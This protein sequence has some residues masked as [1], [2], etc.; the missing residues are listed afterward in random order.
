M[1]HQLAVLEM[2]EGSL[3]DP[4]EQGFGI[5]RLQDLGQRVAC[6]QLADAGRGGQQVQVVVA[7]H[8]HAPLAQ[9][10]HLAQRGQR[11]R[12]AVDEVAGEPERGVVGGRQAGQQ[13]D[14]GGVATLEVADGD[15]HRA[16]G[17]GHC[18]MDVVRFNDV[19][20]A[21]DARYHKSFRA[22]VPAACEGNILRIGIFLE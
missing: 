17:R 6:L 3:A 15:R 22:S 19:S 1:H 13:L 12:P 10:D 7:E 8:G 2:R 20:Q 11:G 9:R 5:G 4:F 14:E 16:G 21:S 18:G